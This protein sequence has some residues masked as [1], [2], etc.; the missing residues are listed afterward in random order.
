[1]LSLHHP[2]FLQRNQPQ[3]K[4]RDFNRNKS[5]YQNYPKTDQKSYVYHN[6]LHK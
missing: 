4:K 3:K 2:S 6:I 1:M 5:P